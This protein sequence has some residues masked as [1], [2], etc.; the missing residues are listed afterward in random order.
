M[1]YRG[2]GFI[3]IFRKKIKTAHA[4]TAEAAL[5]TLYMKKN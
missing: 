5:D 1:N 3:F 2:F 4:I